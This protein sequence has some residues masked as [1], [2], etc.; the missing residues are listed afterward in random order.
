MTT[1]DELVRTQ[2]AIWNDLV[3]RAWVRHAN[4]HDRQ[5]APFGEAAMDA[6]GPI[7]GASVL[8]VG[9]GTGASSAELVRRGARE[10]LGI[11]LS[12][13]M[14][15]AARGGNSR[16]RLH[17]QLGDV[18]ELRDSDRFD[19]I[20]SR[21]GVMFFAEPVSA[22]GHLRTLGTPG[23]RLGFCCWGPPAENPWMA[24]PVMATI[25]V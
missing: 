2:E 12:A 17:F 7:T 4:V 19:V 5:A 6:I 20:F 9:C 13:P 11:D 25:P 3:G 8:D 21:Y 24:V 16:A 14:I 23:A 22:F 1:H 15:D 10:V 18:L